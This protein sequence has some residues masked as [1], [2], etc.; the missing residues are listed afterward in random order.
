[1]SRARSISGAFLIGLGALSIV[2]G[3]RLR[4]D[5]LGAKLLPVALGVV[6]LILGGAHV[7]S[8]D[9]G[10]EPEAPDLRTRSR[11]A[12]IFA[13]LAL[14]VLI[15]PSFGFLPATAVFTVIL[16][17]ALGSYSWVTTVGL[18]VAIA[19]GTHVVFKH[20][21]GMALPVGRF[22]I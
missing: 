13:V 2:E 16:I 15:L 20:W 5:W 11:V 17:R 10:E 4:D 8:R 9:P 7:W 19:V 21:L 1:V 14:Y 12:L 3:L 18:T 22:G 6:L